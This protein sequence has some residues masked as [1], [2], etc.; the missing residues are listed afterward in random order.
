M[1]ENKEEFNRKFDEFWEKRSKD[2]QREEDAYWAKKD[3]D[4]NKSILR[5]RLGC[6]VFLFIALVF[7]S[8]GL[9]L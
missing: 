5:R 3:R 2:R 7:T 6:M 9:L 1:E 8:L 4:F